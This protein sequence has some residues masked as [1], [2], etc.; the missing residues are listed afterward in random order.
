MDNITIRNLRIYGKHGV[1]PE[2]NILGQN[3]YVDAVLYQ[4]VR[5]AGLSDKLEAST[6]YGEVCRF[7]YTF[8][9]ENT[10]RLIET[11]AEKL[12]RAILLAFPLI[13]KITLTVHKPEAPIGLP[14]EDVAVTITRGWHIA[15]IGLG[16][17]MGNREKYIKDACKKL[18]CLEDCRVMQISELIETEPYGGVEQD[19]FLNGAAEVRTLLEPEELL[20][21]LHTIEKEAD[22]TREVHWG[23]RTLDLDILLYDSI[24]YH[25][26]T[27]HIPHVDMENRLFVLQPLSQIAGH[28]FHPVKR[29]TIQDMLK[30]LQP[31]QHPWLQ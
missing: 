5:E 16:S 30:A 10:S 19:K 2:E 17:N 12:A 28:Y 6:N 8:F 1:Y 25:S 29:Q 21:I 4:S 15:Y 13:E 14:V 9:T 7:M 18:N 31:P 3:F 20:N 22:R 23:P 26:Q 27:L 11:A 24:E